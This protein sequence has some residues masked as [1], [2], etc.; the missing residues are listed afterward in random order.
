MRFF[1]ST[2]IDYVNSTP[3]LGHCLEKV[4]ADVIARY[5]R[6]Q[7]EDV[8][9]LSGT[10]E[11][12]LKNVKAAEVHNVSTEKWV[13]RNFQKFYKLKQAL[14]LSY[15]DFIRTTQERHIEGVRKLWLA[16]KKDI[17]KRKYK[18]LYC[19]GD[20]SFHKESEL[21]NGYCP[22]HPGEKPIL[23]EEENYFFRLS[24]HQEKIKKLIE[25]D[26]VKV[27]PL[28][29]K[30]E[31]LNFIKQGLEDICVSRSAE[32]AHQWGI[33]VPGDS[34]QKIWV[35]FDA[36][37]N[38]INALGYAKNAR[39]FEN[40]W[41]KGEKL[42]II[43]KDI[44]RFHAV[45]WIGM[46]LS[47]GIALPNQI[48]V[49]GFMTVNGKKMSKSV[50]NVVD[51]FELIKKYGA[52]PVRYFLLREIPP[53][54]DGDFTYK[55]FIERYNSDLAK[56]LGNMAARVLAMA[57]RVKK[58]FKARDLKAQNEVQ[59]E[60][61]RIEKGF[62]AALVQFKFNKA[63][64][65]IWELVGFC[66]KHIDK[67]RPWEKSEHQ[68]RDICD[69]LLMLFHIAKMLQPFLPQTAEKMF[70]QLGILPPEAREGVYRF[71]IKRGK[72]LFPKI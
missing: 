56:G 12:S 34:S 69:L 29:R 4:Q 24:K 48:F 72:A 31:V 50:G 19:V 2:S 59:K 42:H 68:E 33:D 40:F 3:H 26:I 18:G 7:G 55:K 62:K 44:L 15:T 57:E 13:N 16:C 58:E 20:E 49:H 67:N 65:L 63:L 17:Y 37:S 45:Y 47:A 51:P 8:Y 23:V 43:G 60:I 54:E 35:W 36:L 1:V 64:F 46:L 9:F 53:A 11:N 28:S 61:S 70:S 22:G 39:D 25:A 66:D 10:D 27:V 14:N 41:Q 21:E 32:R 6:A 30:N 38:Y 71:R 52:D 5:F